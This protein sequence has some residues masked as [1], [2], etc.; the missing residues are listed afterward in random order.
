MGKIG[1][2]MW[3]RVRWYL[4]SACLCGLAGLACRTRERSGPGGLGPLV[5]AVLAERPGLWVFQPAGVQEPVPLR[6]AVVKSQGECDPIRSLGGAFV[7]C[8]VPGAPD[9]AVSDRIKEALREVKGVRGDYLKKG[10]VT[11]FA[12]PS[13]TEVVM[14]LAAEEPSFF[15]GLV[16]RGAD[17]VRV[18]NVRLHAYGE[19]GGKK[20]ALL[21][22][23]E[24]DAARVRGVAVAAQLQV[25]VF[26]DTPEGLR[27]A[28][29]FARVEGPLVAPTPAQS[30]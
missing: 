8:A 14:R 28:A 17:E 24:N 2:V 13:Q 4:A 27:A 22:V 25:G 30:Y 18:S 19:R 7:I 16:L 6:I 3:A 9:Q 20:L 5:P 1:A 11:V 23:P 10:P 12:G 29:D 15:A 26:A 21:G